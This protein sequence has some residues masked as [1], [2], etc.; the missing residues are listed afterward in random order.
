MRGALEGELEAED[1]PELHSTPPPPVC[2]RAADVARH[3]AEVDVL[4]IRLARLEAAP[5]ETSL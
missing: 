5:G 2:S 1:L 3:R 4:E